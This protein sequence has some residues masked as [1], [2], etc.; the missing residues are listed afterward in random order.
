[1]YLASVM[2]LLAKY[3]AFELLLHEPTAS[4]DILLSD[5]LRKLLVICYACVTKYSRYKQRTNW[6]QER[7]L[8]IIFE[9]VFHTP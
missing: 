8:I 7:G 9:P 2:Q 1:M 3:L 5:S 4:R 6:P